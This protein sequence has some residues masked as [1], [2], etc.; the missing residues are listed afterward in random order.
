MSKCRLRTANGKSP[1]VTEANPELQSL[2][3]QSTHGALHHFGNLYDRRFRFR[4]SAQFGM[5]RPR[6]WSAL[7][8]FS[9]RLLSH[10]LSNGVDRAAFYLPQA[11]VTTA[12]YFDSISFICSVVH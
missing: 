5:E 9:L 10:V 2:L 11:S 3:S 8:R 6:P 7:D 1:L 12:D 4:V